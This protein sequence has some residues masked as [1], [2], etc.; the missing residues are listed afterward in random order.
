MLTWVVADIFLQ[1]DEGSHNFKENILLVEWP[2]KMIP[3]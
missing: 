3:P 1:V 2:N